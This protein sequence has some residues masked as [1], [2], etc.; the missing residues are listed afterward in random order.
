MTSP[1]ISQSVLGLLIFSSPWA[2]GAELGPHPQDHRFDS[3]A[4]VE[5]LSRN[6]RD[7]DWQALLSGKERVFYL[8]DYHPNPAIAA[9]AA[10]AMAQIKAAGITH[11]ALEL[12][13]ALQPALDAWMRAGEREREL[14][15]FFDEKC[16]PGVAA[17]DLG[18]MKSVRAQGLQLVAIDQESTGFSQ[19]LSPRDRWMAGRLAGILRDPKARILVFCGANHV[20][21]SNQPKLLHELGWSSRSY[22]FLT[23]G[24]NY[25]SKETMDD[26]RK[27]RIYDQEIYELAESLKKTKLGL[28]RLFLSLGKGADFDGYISIPAVRSQKVVG[29]WVDLEEVPA[30]D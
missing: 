26:V 25:K 8:G 3:A 6:A 19:D 15:R 24:V 1:P 14:R 10:S 2:A 9:E 16:G 21:R 18:L 20:R 13:D 17:R 7:L 28:K 5:Y 22:C 23:S 29:L 4:R 12:P 27:S 30:K 11:V